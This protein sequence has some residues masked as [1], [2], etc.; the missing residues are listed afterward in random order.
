MSSTEESKTII[1]EEGTSA[2]KEEWDN[3]AEAY[4]QNVQTMTA[5]SGVQ[6]F[7]LTNS[8]KS[9]RTLEVGAGGGLNSILFASSMQK[10]GS[11][12]FT[13][14]LS[15]NMVEIAR[16]DLKNSSFGKDSSNKVVDLEVTELINPNNVTPETTEK[17]VA[18]FVAN[19]EKLPIVSDSFDSY[20]SNLSL[21]LV[22]NHEN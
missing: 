3:F 6:L 7:N 4:T 20:V 5:C 8:H 15:D 19:N 12:L 14:D 11:V 21:M 17:I 13:C 10:K 1:N 18:T 9:E 22:D 2:I 16:R